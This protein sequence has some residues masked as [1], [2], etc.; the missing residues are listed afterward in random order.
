MK[1]KELES[2][3]ALVCSWDYTNLQL[4]VSIL[5]GDKQLKASFLDQ[6]GLLFELIGKAEIE[7]LETLPYWI[8]NHVTTP[9]I[10]YQEQLIPLLETMPIHELALVDKGLKAVPW[11]VL[12]LKKMKVLTLAQNEI[13]SLPSSIVNL[14]QLNK[15]N[16]EN[17]LLTALPENIGEMKSLDRLYLDFN[18]IEAL[19]ESIGELENL[20]SLCLEDSEIRKLPQSMK[21][22]KN[23]SWF[24][25]EKTP[26]GNHFGLTYGEYISVEDERFLKYLS[27]EIKEEDV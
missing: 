8:S 4:A 27:T 20:Y 22:L 21:N 13:K 16:M 2:L 18:H 25:M 10:P 26:L 19:P 7:T 15:I 1:N 5:Q 6:F 11:W 23:L 24:S 14:K 3:V 12:H 17:N 9:N